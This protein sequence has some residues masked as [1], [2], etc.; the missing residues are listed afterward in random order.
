MILRSEDANIHQ[1][2]VIVVIRHIHNHKIICAD[3][4]KHR[5]P[6][7][8]VKETILKLFSEGKTPSKALLCLKKQLC[9]EK[10]NDYY[11]FAG[12]RGELPDPAW[13]YNLYYTTFKMNF[14]SSHGESMMISLKDAIEEY[15]Q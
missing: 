6:S 1:T 7:E 15:D 10:G 3:V 8:E 9:H 11:I 4:L 5:F 2:K 13:V 12:D 14:G